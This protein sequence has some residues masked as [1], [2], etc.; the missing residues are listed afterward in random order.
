MDSLCIINVAP[1]QFATSIAI[2]CVCNGERVRTELL[3]L[4]RPVPVEDNL[5]TSCDSPFFQKLLIPPPLPILI[6]RLN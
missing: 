4:I 3:F 1:K 6:L 2:V 5:V